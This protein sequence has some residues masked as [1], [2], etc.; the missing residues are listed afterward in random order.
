AAMAGLLER[1]GTG[2]SFHAGPVRT[3]M[4]T[5]TARQVRTTRHFAPGI[6][7]LIINCNLSWAKSVRT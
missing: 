7:S 2:D 4:P 6:F 1:A 3:V 5:T